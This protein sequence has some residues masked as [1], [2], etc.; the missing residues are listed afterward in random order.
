MPDIR[1]LVGRIQVQNV[2]N[3]QIS[4]F[5]YVIGAKTRTKHEMKGV[6]SAGVG[7]CT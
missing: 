3:E 7:V 1:R 4:S 6:Q 5:P 2:L